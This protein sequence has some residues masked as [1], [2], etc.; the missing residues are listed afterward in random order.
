MEWS[1]DKI[2]E[3]LEV[4]QTE[5]C[6]WDT[7]EKAHKNRGAQTDAW[8]RIVQVLPFQTTVQGFKKK[9]ISYG[10]LQNPSK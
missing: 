8:R 7:R 2:I 6:L 1:N 3:F 5:P 4:F 10:I 9:R